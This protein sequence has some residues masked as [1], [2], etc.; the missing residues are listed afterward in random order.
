MYTV[1]D[2]PAQ[3]NSP[4]Q[5]FSTKIANAA[6]QLRELCNNSRSHFWNSD[7][8]RMKCGVWRFK[9]GN[10]L[11]QKHM[12]F[13]MIGRCWVPPREIAIEIAIYIW[14][15]LSGQYSLM[16]TVGELTNT[17]G[18]FN[19]FSFT[20]HSYLNNLGMLLIEWYFIKYFRCKY[21]PLSAKRVIPNL[22][23]FNSLWKHT[24]HRLLL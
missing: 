16:L 9:E 21:V 14:L 22:L 6:L 13:S 10:C 1:F 24:M 3:R 20:L 8:T 15:L 12:Y 4:K 23:M 19:V 5:W 2:H 17:I 7:S 11:F 18:I